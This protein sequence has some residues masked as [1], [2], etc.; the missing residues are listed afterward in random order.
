MFKISL[1]GIPLQERHNSE[2]IIVR[3]LS[4]TALS[5]YAEVH[6]RHDN[7]VTVVGGGGGLEEGHTPLYLFRTF[8]T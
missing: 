4:T 3:N 8:G 2:Q 7:F 5:W 6:L 1:S